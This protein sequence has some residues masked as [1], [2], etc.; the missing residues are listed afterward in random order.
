[1][2]LGSQGIRRKTL[3]R[4]GRRRGARTGFT[5]VEL[6]VVMVVIGILLGFAVPN[7]VSMTQRTKRASCLSNQRNLVPHATLYAADHKLLDGVVNVSE[8][9]AEGRVPAGLTECPTSDT[10]DHDD[11]EITFVGGVVVDVTCLIQ[12]AEHEWHP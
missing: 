6:A 7:Y 3:P 8:L 5:L 11:Y 9:L 10:P 2:V 12:G 1:M 4:G